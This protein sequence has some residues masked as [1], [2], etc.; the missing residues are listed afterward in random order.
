LTSY[1]G[2]T[3]ILKPPACGGD[4]YP[5]QID[6]AAYFRVSGLVLEYATG[7][8]SADIY[9][10]GGAHDD[11]V[12]GNELAWSQ[13]QGMFIDDT[14]S[15]IW[16]VGNKIHDN[17]FG[18]VSGQHQSH[19]I[20]ME[21]T[22]NVVADNVIYNQPYGFGVQVY[23]LDTNPVVVNNTIVHNGHSGI[24][25][26]G[27][28]GVTGAVVANNVLAYNGSWGIEQDTNPPSSCT[29]THNIMWGNSGG[30][31]E[32]G[33]TGCTFTANQT[34]DPLFVSDSAANF[35]VQAGSPTIDAGVSGYSYGAAFSG[36]ARP[37]GAAFDIGA[38]EH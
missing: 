10:W 11:Q 38:F 4:C 6:G 12:V 31:V 21:G 33:Y 15:N 32:S 8:S 22:A 23:P 13:D 17:G 34:V 3:A 28:G 9:V 36:V 5:L 16:I 29:V 25:L 7:T 26:G 35:D 1:P 37:Q 19:G 30:S 20:Y 27:A 2:E 18:H 14:T 24:V